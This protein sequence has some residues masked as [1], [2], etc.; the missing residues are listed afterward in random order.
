M[1]F[2]TRK[3]NFSDM[4]KS[5]LELKV[6][7][8]IFIGLVLLGLLL[9]QF[10]KGASMFRPTYT[11]FVTASDVGGLKPRASVLMSGVQI[12]TVK[13]ISLNP[14]GTNVTIT[15]TIYKEYVIRDDAE[16]QIKQSGFLGDN[17]VAINP[18]ANKGRELA[19]QGRAHALEPFNLQEVARSAAGFVQRV[20]EAAAK[21]NEA[22]SDVRRY[23][24]NEHT[25]TNLAATV[26]TMR[27]ASERA[28]ATVEEI[29]SL[30]VTNGPAVALSASNIALASAELRQFAGSLNEVIDRNDDSIAASVKNV[31]DS[32][33]LLKSILEDARAGKGLAGALL[34]DERVASNVSDMVYNLSITSSN[35]NRLGLWGILWSKKPPRTSESESSSEPL[36][37]PRD[38]NRP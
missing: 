20:D 36:R 5:R 35:L 19:D 21:L 6:G 34:Q 27:T 31:E 28:M 29:N 33:V 22:I 13:D 18:K 38:P 4:S 16:F 23:A 14:S 10:S 37:T 1:A 2:P 30:F 3:R 12:G 9:L 8:F 24:L 15:L 17:F 32:T 26:D 7:V 11:L 25:L